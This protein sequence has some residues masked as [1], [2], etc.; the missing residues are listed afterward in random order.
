MD[1]ECMV[2]GEPY[3][4]WRVGVFEEEMNF[5]YRIS[6]TNMLFVT[7]RTLVVARVLLCFS[8]IFIHALISK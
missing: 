6:S 2:K 7:P 3:D 8:C 5:G 1:A 4:R